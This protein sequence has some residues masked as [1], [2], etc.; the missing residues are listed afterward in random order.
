[1]G[2]GIRICSFSSTA[3]E[4]KKSGRNENGVLYALKYHPRISTFDMCDKA[5]LRNIIEKLE[6]KKL[7]QR[8][9]EPYPWHKWSLT[10]KGKREIIIQEPRA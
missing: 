1:M 6:K 2:S 5:W 4:L 9:D 8:E 7:I 3:A 10:D